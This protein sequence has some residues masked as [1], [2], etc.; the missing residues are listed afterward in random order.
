MDNNYLRHYGVVGMSWHIRRG[1]KRVTKLSKKTDKMLDK[2]D[3][4]RKFDPDQIRNQNMKVR[5]LD[6][7]NNKRIKK[8][9]KYLNN[10]RLVDRMFDIKKDPKKIEKVKAHLDRSEIL[11]KKLSDLRSSVHQIKMDLLM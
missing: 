5:Q 8:I 3:R 1:E 2:I 7:K 10:E 4:K 11:S 9:K 6:Y